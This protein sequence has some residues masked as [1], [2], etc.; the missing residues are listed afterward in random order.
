MPV[1]TEAVRRFAEEP[2]GE[3]SEHRPPE[4]RILTPSFCLGFS[5]SPT[6]SNVTRLRTTEVGL[7]QTIEEVRVA[8]RGMGYTGLSWTIGP[9]CEPA[10]L[11]DLL[12]AR[13]FMRATRPPYEPEAHAMALVQPPPPVPNNVEARLVRTYDEYVQALRIA[14]EAFEVPEEGQAGWLAAAPEVFKQQDGVGRMTLL[15]FVD[16]RPVGF[17][18]AAGGPNGLLLCG[19]GVLP[20]AR[21]K[22]AYR[23]LLAARWKVAADLGTPALVIQ[24]GAMSKPIA[25]RSGFEP[26]C[27]LDIFLDPQF[28]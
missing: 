26:I 8:V 7:D 23:A 17:G 4:A 20:T 14:M 6:Q 18:F 22:G 10:G 13:G 24:A 25:E 28:G 3:I 5:P 21:G 16:G 27:R 2:E 19:S 12:L 9:S 15:A 1:L 11:S